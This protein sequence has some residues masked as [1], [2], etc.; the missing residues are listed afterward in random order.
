[1]AKIDR[2]LFEGLRHLPPFAPW[3]M[4][5]SFMFPFALFFFDFGRTERVVNSLLGLVVSSFLRSPL[6][7]FSSFPVMESFFYPEPGCPGYPTPLV[8]AR[9]LTTRSLSFP[10]ALHFR[11]P[12]ACGD[13]EF[14]SFRV[15][16]F[17]FFFLMYDSKSEPCLCLQ[18]PPMPP[19][20]LATSWCTQGPCIRAV[21]LRYPELHSNG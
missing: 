13:L 2:P 15:F 11:I 21:T 8:S 14:P 9:V 6:S 3:F 16:P 7:L 1:V 10:L 12:C 18:W 19:G 20:C 17:F 5:G 4:E